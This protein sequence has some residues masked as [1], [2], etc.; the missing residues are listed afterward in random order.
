MALQKPP[1]KLSSLK[2]RGSSAQT[3]VEHP[4][5]QDSKLNGIPP[6]FLGSCSVCPKE[7][8][9]LLAVVWLHD[10]GCVSWNMPYLKDVEVSLEQSLASL[11]LCQDTEQCV[12]PLPSTY[13]RESPKP[14]EGGWLSPK[15]Q[16]QNEKAL[17]A[18]Q[19][20]STFLQISV[21][22]SE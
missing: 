19:K 9:S 14:G 22:S 4:W 15:K 6:P 17:K 8:A 5:K 3:A 18:L 13:Y 7:A 16:K 1:P 12:R 10:G 20:E 11:Y 21:M 2:L